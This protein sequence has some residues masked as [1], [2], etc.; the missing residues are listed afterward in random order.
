MSPLITLT[1]WAKQGIATAIEVAIKTALSM[2]ETGKEAS[3]D[4]AGIGYRSL[5]VRMGWGHAG[6]YPWIVQANIM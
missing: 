2:R 6:R 3:G 4:A 5:A 1:S